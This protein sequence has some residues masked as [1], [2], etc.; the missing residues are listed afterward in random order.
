MGST[1]GLHV[2]PRE[3]WAAGDPC[4]LRNPFSVGI[5]FVLFPTVNHSMHSLIEVREWALSSL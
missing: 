2:G 3:R 5:W 4:F 1:L